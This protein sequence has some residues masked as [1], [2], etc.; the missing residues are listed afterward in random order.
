MRATHFHPQ[1][2]AGRSVRDVDVPKPPDVHPR[3]FLRREHLAEMKEKAARPGLRALW[4]QILADGNWA[5]GENAIARL[6]QAS[7]WRSACRVVNGLCAALE[8]R[9]LLYLFDGDEAKGREA[10]ELA[11]RAVEAASLAEG[12]S[13]IHR[14]TGRLMTGAALVYDWC[15]PLLRDEEKQATVA[16]LER[17]A[18]TFECGYP[19]VRQGAV[20]GHLGEAQVMRDM[21]SAGIA[22]ADEQPEMY[23]VAAE[24]FFREMVPAR[25]FTYLAGMHHQGFS[26][27][28]YRYIWETHAA[29]I[30]RR[31]CGIDVFSE[32]HGR[33]PYHWLYAFRPD[34]Q[35]IRDGDLIFDVPPADMLMMV[36]S[37]YGDPVLQGASEK[38]RAIEEECFTENPS[39]E[40]T[41][42]MKLLFIDPD[43]P[44][45]PYDDLPLT[46][47]FGYPMGQMIARTGWEEGTDAPVVVANMKV[48]IYQFA[49]HQHL[50]AGGFQIYYKAPLAIDSGA[51][52]RYGSE[53][54][55]N[56]YKRTIA[57]N[58]LLVHDPGETFRSSRGIAPSND[59]GQRTPNNR[60]E[61]RNL[62]ILLSE[63][64]RVADVLGQQVGPDFRAPEYSYLKGNLTGAY[65]DKVTDYKRAFVFLDLGDE[66]HPAALIVCDWVRASDPAFR[67]TWLLHSIEEPEVDGAQVTICL[68][69][70]E[71]GYRGKLVNHTLLPA[72]VSIEKIGGP[73]REFWVD[74]E[75]RELISPVD[76][77]VQAGA[78]RI[79]VSPAEARKADLLLN[80]MQ[81]MDADEPTVLP[82]AQLETETMIGVRIAGRCVWFSKSGE[83][84]SDDVSIAGSGTGD[85]SVFVVTDLAAGFWKVAGDDPSGPIEVTETGGVLRFEGGLD[86]YVLTRISGH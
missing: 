51:Y 59:G 15:Y 38:L 69:D 32:A 81:V 19:P 64:Y 47:Y 14:A 53:H 9:A 23:Q 41:P 72:E 78:W 31:M 65:S 34:G 28:P 35:F 70:S 11:V 75:N 54:D 85:R 60:S 76:D 61:P 29:W 66:R 73:G 48:G 30:F 42:V 26:Y 68:R 52:K 25:D 39:M 4:Q 8:S 63:G 71:A 67:K 84:V 79:E 56:Y 83:R 43:L 17:L 80:V 57:H 20:T 10:V 22:I 3:L 16:H 18:G 5:D 33:V 13:D 2:H 37:Y 40:L 74:G 1:V 58:A 44:A 62:E 12:R 27:G 77:R 21:L 49:N 45:Q 46:G 6:N 7:D 55:Q 82:V 24:R 36:A 50:D 86:S